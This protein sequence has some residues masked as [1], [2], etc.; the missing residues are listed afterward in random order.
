MYSG[1]EWTDEIAGSPQIAG[2][3]TPEAALE[4]HAGH[5]CHLSYD[6]PPCCVTSLGE[7]QGPSWGTGC[8]PEGDFIEHRQEL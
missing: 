4:K 3:E 6:G 7:R 1:W 8:T 5:R 2:A